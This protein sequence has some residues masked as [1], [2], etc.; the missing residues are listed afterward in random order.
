METRVI[1]SQTVGRRCRL[2]GWWTRHP[3]SVRYAH[4][5]G[6]P[7]H[8]ALW[9]Y[10]AVEKTLPI[11]LQSL[12][13]LVLLFAQPV[14]AAPGVVFRA[15]VAP[16]AGRRFSGG[17]PLRNHADG[18]LQDGQG[19]LGHL[20]AQ[21]RHAPLPSGRLRS[22]VRS[23]SQPGPSLPIHCRSK[24]ETDMNVDR[25][26][27]LGPDQSAPAR[28]SW[29]RSTRDSRGGA[30]WSVSAAT[31]DRRPNPPKGMMP[32]GWLPTQA[33][34]KRWVSF[35]TNLNIQSDCHPDLRDSQCVT[36]QS[37]AIRW[38]QFPRTLA[39][40]QPPP[41]ETLPTARSVHHPSTAGPTRRPALSE[42]RFFLK[43]FGAGDQT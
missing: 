2:G 39:W 5:Y 23:T 12:W 16:Q 27:E 1:V 33:F 29:C 21:S 10:T 28:P 38:R 18:P 24:S 31:I 4:L 17:L 14:I 32:A 26:R 19:Y 34:A 3:A 11:G 6:A 20:R 30:N 15:A 41:R 8:M 40:P 36:P 25:Q 35:V 43:N 42:V 22:S 13:I 9:R 7:R 37:L